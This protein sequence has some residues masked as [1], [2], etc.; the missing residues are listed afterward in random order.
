MSQIL[1]TACILSQ[2]TKGNSSLFLL[3]KRE[4]LPLEFHKILLIS[5]VSIDFVRFRYGSADLPAYLQRHF[6]IALLRHTYA[7]HMNI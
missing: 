4:L 5:K 3:R 2:L 1:D 7:L 6:K